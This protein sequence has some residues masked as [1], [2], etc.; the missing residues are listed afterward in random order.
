[1]IKNLWNN[2]KSWFKKDD[3]VEIPNPFPT[4]NFTS[5]ELSPETKARMEAIQKRIDDA[6]VKSLNFSWNWEELTKGDKSLDEVANS[7]CKILEDF[8]DGKVE[9]VEIIEV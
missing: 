4:P 9:L 2:I 8:F 6:G 5:K 1:M 7:I 3:M